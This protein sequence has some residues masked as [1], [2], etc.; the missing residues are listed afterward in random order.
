MPVREI[1]PAPCTQAC[2]AGVQVKAYVSLIAE[3]RFGEALEVVRRR[4]PLPGICGR[5][6]D[7][8]CEMACRRGRA[9]EAIAIRALKRFVADQE[10]EF[11]LPAPPPGPAKPWQ[12]AVIGSG[13]AGLTAAYD[14]RL[15]GFPVTVF[16]SAT[17]PGGM[18][19][20]GI[21][22]YR[23][24]RDI[25]DAEID[26]LVRAGVEIKTGHRL[27]GDLDLEQLL[28]DDYDAALL[29]TGAPLGR[30]L[31][32]PGEDDHDEIEDALTFLR[33]V[34]DGD[35]TPVGRRVIVIG[36]GSTAVEAA[37]AARRL[38]AESV[39]I[40]YRRSRN[41]LLAGEEEIEAA[42]AEGIRF[43]FLVTPFKVLSDGGRFGGLECFEVGLGEADASGRRRPITIPGTEFQLEADRVFAAVGQE[44]DLAFLPSRGRTRMLDS[45]KLF[46]D[47]TTAMTRLTGVFA[48][49][50][51][52]TGPATVIEA[53]AAGHRS[54]ESIRHFLEEGRPAIRE[55]R[56]ERQAPAEY[57]LPDEPPLEAMR[58]RPA[59]ITPEAG[60]EF[61]EVEQAFSEKDAVAEARR[62][63]RCGPCGECRVCATT[64]NRRHVMVRASGPATPGSTALLRVPAGVALSLATADPAPGWLLPEA[65]PG[66][67]HDVDVSRGVKVELLPVRA[68]IVPSRCRGCGQ[69]ADVCPFHAIGLPNG[70]GDDLCSRLEPA[71]C[72]GCN[73]CTAVC[74]TKATI[75]ST[76][77]PEWW[78]HRLEDVFEA[79]REQKGEATPYVVL[80]CQR[81]AGALEAALDRP[82]IHVEV[83]RF[84]CVGQVDAGMLVD[85]LRQ[86]AHRVLVSGCSQDR[87]RFDSG[88]LMA[89][90]QVQR[91]RATLKLLGMDENRIVTNWS[92]GRA[93]D[94]LEEP[95]AEFVHAAPAGTAPKP[96][97]D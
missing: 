7:H 88:A 44:V 4:C 25:L 77:S 42:E 73:L 40:L 8:P 34:N 57:E 66:R 97:V 20:Y 1:K 18:L 23:L 46:V 52:V 78:A 38:G 24:P 36:G 9:E 79:A 31:G 96:A 19:R 70:N 27:G 86:G 63:L 49:G 67:L 72:R 30:K 48:A 61:A 85:L 58:I 80:A 89:L 54:A 5:V 62:C 14:L 47:D 2:P 76:L 64:C 35:R 3:E 45:R 15:S 39:Q 92:P 69:C 6:C 26:V 60:R 71:L 53:M 87:C 68:D 81:R 74:P 82:G 55:Q 16:E 83:I 28:S 37:R 90:Q 93:F 32:I 17:E 13:P 59:T 84:R 22:A 11:P 41:Q 29:A 51:L 56:P 65:R 95:I 33:R 94:R 21:T 10:R 91:A 75:P 12:V 43:R 50:D